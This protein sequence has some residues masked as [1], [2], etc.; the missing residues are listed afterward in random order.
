MTGGR[1]PHKVTC[2]LLKRKDKEGTEKSAV[3]RPKERSQAYPKISSHQVNAKRKNGTG[4]KLPSKVTG[5]RGQYPW[6]CSGSPFPTSIGNG[7]V[8]WNVKLSK[9]AMFV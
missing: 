4:N 1:C 8:G 6:Q 3:M 5:T 9:E 2:W 7:G